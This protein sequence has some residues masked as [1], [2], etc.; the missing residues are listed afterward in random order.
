M[1]IKTNY[2]KTA[3]VLRMHG[4]KG[5]SD[6]SPEGASEG[7]FFPPVPT[8]QTTTNKQKDE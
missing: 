4:G 1:V 5:S 2:I 6:R 7:D 3:A 8:P